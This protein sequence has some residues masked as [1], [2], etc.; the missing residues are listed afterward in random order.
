M[1]LASVVLLCCFIRAVLAV[2]QFEAG[3]A[4]FE[5]RDYRAAVAAF[6][7]LAEAGDP[8]AQ[9]ML[10]RLY[11][12]GNGVI[13]DFVSAHQ[14]FNL[15]AANGHRQADAARES[16]AVQMT[17][18][19]IAAA[20]Q[21]AR[22]FQQ[23]D[24]PLD[25]D[26]GDIPVV[27][28]SPEEPLPAPPPPVDQA[29]V[30]RIQLALSQRGYDIGPITGEVDEALGDAILDYQLT[31]FLPVDGQ[32]SEALLARLLG[33]TGERP[34]ISRGASAP[35]PAPEPRWIWRRILLEDSFRDGDYERNPAWRVDNG[36]FWV[37]PGR[38]LRSVVDADGEVQQ[39]QIHVPRTINNAFAIDLSLV[40]RRNSGRLEFGPYQDN[41]GNGY[42]L[43][44]YP[45]HATGFELRR[46][47]PGGNTVIAR[48]Q[49][50]FDLETGGAHKLLWTRDAQGRMTIRLND[51][52][53]LEVQDQNFQ[54]PF[55]GFVLVNQGGD[56]NLRRI[57]IKGGN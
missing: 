16:L 40:S 42:R 30:A 45:A 37:E 19:Q 55:D 10:G 48:S 23:G 2:S 56:Y 7:P 31:H 12:R 43:I 13:Q 5:A 39:A 9:Y 18:E 6:E 26:S 54:E 27:R 44:Y 1:R 57:A 35:E 15:A 14:W 11:A 24:V 38:G 50:R 32:P 46:L 47:A 34:T 41:P 36:Q 3:M 20:Q 28:L 51:N 53:L 21:A 52:V 17:A 4:A 22:R 25:E 33:E 8:D 29:T 49:R